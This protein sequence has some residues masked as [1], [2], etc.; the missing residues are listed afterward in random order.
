MRTESEILCRVLKFS[1]ESDDAKAVI[2]HVVR[3]LKEELSADFIGFFWDVNK[4][5]YDACND[6][7]CTAISDYLKKETSGLMQHFCTSPEK[8]VMKKELPQFKLIKYVLPVIFQEKILGVLFIL[9]NDEHKHHFEERKH[10]VQ[11]LMHQLALYLAGAEYSF[12]IR[13]G[14][15]ESINGMISVIEAL[16][17]YTRNHSKNVANYALL[18]A[19]ELSLPPQI[20]EHVYYGA[21]FHDIG[22]IGIPISIIHKQ[23]KLT[24]SEYNIIKHHPEKGALI[25]SNFSIFSD[26]IPIVL[27]HHE[28]FDGSGY[29]DGLK[30]EKIPLGARLVAIVD[31]YDALTTN[32]SY[33]KAQHGGE[34]IEI[35]KKSSPD[36]F[37]PDLVKAFVEVEK[38]L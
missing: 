9:F 23:S 21:L 25:L 30:A 5:F 24:D 29:P 26:I 18:L 36:Q 4:N 34:A 3:V 2:E 20:I 11:V 16:D 13:Q 1:V 7:Q 19:E 33:H 38:H 8:E 37:D 28:H 17:S 32:R 6:E 31:A 14:R 22:K 27:H 10:L 15:Y 12:S 35:I